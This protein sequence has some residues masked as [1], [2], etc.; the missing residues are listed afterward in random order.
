MIR[1]ASLD[2]DTLKEPK[3]RIGSASQAKQIVSDLLYDDEIRQDRRAKM[4]GLIDGNQPFHRETLISKGMADCPNFNLREAEGMLEAAKT[5]YYD[6]VFE[7][8]RF[9]NITFD[10][11]EADEEIN[12]EWSEIISEEYHKILDEWNGFDNMMQLH[13]YQMCYYGVG[14]LFWP[15]HLNWQAEAIK[16][17][18]ALVPMRTKADVTRIPLLVVLHRFRVDYLMKS[19]QNE[20]SAK[21]AGWE[22]ELVKKEISKVEKQG[23]SVGGH[24]AWTERFQQ[25]HRHGDLFYATTQTEDVRVASLFVPSISDGKISHYMIGRNPESKEDEKTAPADNEKEEGYLFKVK[26]K[27]DS[28]SQIICPF[29]FDTGPDGEWHG[30]KGL[31]PKIYDFCDVSNRMT[32][33]MI[34]GAIIGSGLVLEAQDAT[35]LQDFQLQLIG[36]ST[37]VSPGSKVAQTRIAESL[38]GAITMKRELGMT[39]SQN[40]GEYRQRT[41][42]QQEPTLGQAQMNAQGRASLSKSAIN[43]YSKSMDMFHRETLRRLLNPALTTNQPG[44]KEADYFRKCC[45]KRG[46]PEEALKFEHVARVKTVLSLGYGSPAL[47]DMAAKELISLTPAMDENGKRAA[48]RARV[49]AIPGVGQSMVD[50]YFPKLTKTRQAEDHVW[51]AMLENN[52]LR[53]LHGE[54]YV[55]SRQNHVTHF[56]VHYGDAIEHLKGMQGGVSRPEEVVI[57]LDNV[58]PHLKEHLDKV[59]RVDV[60]SALASGKRPQKQSPE[61]KQMEKAWLQLSKVADKLHKDLKQKNAQQPNGQGAQVDPEMMMEM[62]KIHGELALKREKMMG[63]LRLK[64]EDQ[65]F[66][67]RLK[68]ADK[69]MDIRREMNGSLLESFR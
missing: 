41:E 16:I 30:I 28:F 7:V 31:G 4:Q 66:K 8:P 61:H 25:A 23:V 14:P 42:G 62:Q 38:D 2:S 10:F 44:G 68:D 48:F 18:R 37:V 22:P 53:Q 69:A 56:K 40:T 27:Y 1:L 20:A 13:Q 63:S 32:M 47:R 12:Q 6:L 29:F 34:R 21:K 24:G 46:I 49:A 9:A 36:G 67:H 45:M 60:V 50:V 64:A 26:D 17:G 65:M 33:H 52:A 54:T 11:Y 3:T 39:L 59:P 19:I 35:A 43:R 15:H 51:D 5:P 58:G 57:H 55:T